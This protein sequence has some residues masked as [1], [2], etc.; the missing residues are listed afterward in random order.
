MTALVLAA[1]FPESAPS[2][3]AGADRWL[4]DIIECELRELAAVVV[5]DLADG[6]AAEVFD[7]A[8]DFVVLAN[9]QLERG[10]AVAADNARRAAENEILI[11]RRRVTPLGRPT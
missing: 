2:I 11:A 7:R 8:R 3:I 1:R 10:D 6:L 4:A 5:D 9:L